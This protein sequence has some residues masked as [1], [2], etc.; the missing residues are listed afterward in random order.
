[1]GRDKLPGHPLLGGFVL[2]GAGDMAEQGR[3]AAEQQ[4]GLLP[5]L[6]PPN[7]SLVVV[8]P[9]KHLSHD[10]PAALPEPEHH[11]AK[12][13]SGFPV[14]SLLSSAMPSPPGAP[15]LPHRPQTRA[16]GRASGSPS[17]REE[18]RGQLRLLTPS[19]LGLQA[20]MQTR[21]MQG[22]VPRRG[23]RSR[24]RSINCHRAP[25]R[26]K[27]RPSM[28][29]LGQTGLPGGQGPGC[30]PPSHRCRQGVR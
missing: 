29:H 4:P 22:P 9:G 10:G 18:E 28:E 15:S 6:L 19:W 13:V 7:P 25:G 24:K 5:P 8:A 14:V 30:V 2:P 1:M 16:K 21:A 12:P 11:G 23:I 26:A 20:L 27:A 17:E 3:K